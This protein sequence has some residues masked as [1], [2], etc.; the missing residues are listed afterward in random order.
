MRKRDMRKGDIGEVWLLGFPTAEADELFAALEAA[1]ASATVFEPRVK[2]P[3]G[4][5]EPYAPSN[6]LSLGITLAIL[7]PELP[8][9]LALDAAKK[10]QD[11]LKGRELR[12]VVTAA[13][14]D[15]DVFSDLLEADRLL[16]VS[17]RP[18]GV[19]DLVTLSIHIRPAR[20]AAQW[21]F[22]EDSRSLFA[23]DSALEIARALSVETDLWRAG[24]SVEPTAVELVVADRAYCWAYDSEH[25]VLFARDEGG[26]RTESAATG[27]LGWVARTGRTVRI[28]DLYRDP[29]FDP[30]LDDPR[31]RGPAGAV[32]YLAVPVMSNGSV[33]AVLST[34]RDPSRGSD[35]APFTPRDEAVLESLAAEIGRPFEQLWRE[36]AL[37]RT[38][39]H[40]LPGVSGL[41]S[42]ATDLFR[43]EALAEHTRGDR[44]AGDVLRFMP[45]WTRAA[46]A[47]LL[48]AVICLTGAAAVLEVDRWVSAPALVLERSDDSESDII[49]ALFPAKERGRLRVGQTLRLIFDDGTILERPIEALAPGLIAPGVIEE[50]FGPT[51]KGALP[52]NRAVAWAETRV[53]EGSGPDGLYPG[54]GGR[55]EVRVGSRRVLEALWRGATDD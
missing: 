20:P 48:A 44:Q 1:G 49:V 51:L 8:G 32:P 22:G 25:D 21:A 15:L 36:E 13:G 54:L 23:A 11:E 28:D 4:T 24:A 19:G 30:A 42:G 17:R 45:R 50:R 40:A 26:R 2:Q 41:R 33:L 3:P 5:P 29:R 52:L 47:L 9:E 27:L 35:T 34:L 53:S 43:P 16:Y 6:D 38:F 12:F 14:E 39:E 55:A 18:P 10:L 37:R 7:G 46:Y 31:S